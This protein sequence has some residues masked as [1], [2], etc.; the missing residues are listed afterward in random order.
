MGDDPLTS[1]QEVRLLN[2][3]GQSWQRMCELYGFA[4]RN[5]SRIE[6]CETDRVTPDGERWPEVKEASYSTFVQLSSGIDNLISSMIL[7]YRMRDE[8]HH[9]RRRIIQDLHN[10]NPS[11]AEYLEK[12]FCKSREQSIFRATR[13]A[14]V[15]G[16]PPFEIVV[17]DDPF[18]Y[19]MAR[20]AKKEPLI[21]RLREEYARIVTGSAGLVELL[22]PPNL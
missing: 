19:L 20:S 5:I 15:H 21:P 8:G 7:H 14:M 13:C 22:T 17:G 11:I 16:L 6:G 9:I 18:R 12:R 10:E 3:A 4:Q 2:G 1:L